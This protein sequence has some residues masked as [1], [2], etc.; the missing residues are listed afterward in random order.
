VSTDGEVLLDWVVWEQ[1]NFFYD[2][3]KPDRQDLRVIHRSAN[4]ALFL[5]LSRFLECQPVCL[6]K[7]R[8]HIIGW[9]SFVL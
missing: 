7:L 1:I 8:T 9:G 3:H 2:S 4:L 6:T 5:C